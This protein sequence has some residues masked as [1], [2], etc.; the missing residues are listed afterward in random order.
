[1]H[2]EKRCILEMLNPL[3]SSMLLLL[4][5]WHRDGFKSQPKHARASAKSFM[6]SSWNA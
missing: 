5:W 4:I 6:T 1:L 3:I 2:S